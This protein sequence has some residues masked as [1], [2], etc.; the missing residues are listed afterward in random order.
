MRAP[1]RALTI[2]AALIAALLS[3]A[4]WAQEKT[5][6]T[7]QERMKSCNVEATS[8]NLKGDARK[9]FMSDCLAG[10]TATGGKAQQGTAA[11]TQAPS[12]RSEPSATT[13]ATQPPSRQPA[14]PSTAGAAAAAGQFASEADARRHC[15]RDQVV[16]ANND[17]H[18]YHF[19]GNKNY[20]NTKQGAFMCQQES[21]RAGFRPAKNE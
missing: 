10:K 1:L 8:E 9:S 11:P 3:P 18:I 16:W 17:S 2:S 15:P 7:Q 13:G 4:A 14:T 5:P 12:S 20:G 19:A 6:T 21:D